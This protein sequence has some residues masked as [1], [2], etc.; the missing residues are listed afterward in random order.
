M[1][2]IKYCLLVILFLFLLPLHADAQGGKDHKIYL[3]IITCDPCDWG[4]TMSDWKYIKPEATTNYVKNPSAETTGNFAAEGGTT[5]TR[6]TTYS[7]YGLYSYR[8][9]CNNNN[10][11]AEITLSALSNAIHYVTLR[12]RGTLPAAWDWSLDDAT[13]NAPTLIEAIDG[14]WD[15]YGFEFPA[16]QANGSTK[17]SIHQ[18]GAGSGDFYLDGIQVEQKDDYH[19][20]YCDGTQSGCEWNGAEH[21]TT[22]VDVA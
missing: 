7:H 13:Y 19:T 6:S 17:L 9:Q 4:P 20:T 11:G 10:E 16:A 14:D 21:A 12:V 8:V 18:N 22:G 1:K 15:L 3:P 5:V 2:T